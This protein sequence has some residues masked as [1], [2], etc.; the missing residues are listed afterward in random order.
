MLWKHEKHTDKAK[1]I[2]VMAGHFV[3]SKLNHFE[4]DLC[5]CSTVTVPGMRSACEG[6][7]LVGRQAAEGGYK[8]GTEA[9]REA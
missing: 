5:V 8:N 6:L 1:A 9:H 2:S 4:E 7:L 3:S